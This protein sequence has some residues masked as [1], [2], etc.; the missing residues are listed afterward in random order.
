MLKV[1]TD[2]ERMADRATDIAK[3]V[4]RL[5]GDAPP[6]PLLDIPL[7]AQRVQEMNREALDAWVQGDSERARRMA[8]RDDEIDGLYR[9][10]FDELL[11]VMQSDARGRSAPPRTCC[12]SPT[13]WSA[14]ATTPPTWASGRSTRRPASCR[15]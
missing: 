1:V 3:V 6:K 10:L 2:L 4:L 7:M 14:S 11:Q 8:E 9:R 12:W 5:D 13:T 15:T